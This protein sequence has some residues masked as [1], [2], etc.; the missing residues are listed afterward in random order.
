VAV[1]DLNGDGSPDIITSN[2]A[3]NT[4]SALLGNG[5]G[6]FQPQVTFSTDLAPVQTVI[7]DVNGD[8]RP[9]LITV[10][11]HDASVSVLI[12]NGD[13]TF[14]PL[15]NATGVRVVDTPFLADINGDGI[16]DSV[17]MDRSGNI[18]F[19][20]GL[21]GSNDSF[22]PPV[23]LNPGRPARDIAL[24]NTV[25]GLAIAAADAQLDPTLSSNTFAI[26]ISLYTI[27]R[28]GTVNRTV[29]FTTNSLPT[30]IA[31]ADLLGNGLDSIV[32]ADAL[33][34]TVTVALQTAPGVFAAP[35]TVPVGSAPADITFADVNG[36]G[37]PDIVVSDQASGEV[38][39]LLN[40]ANHAFTK[41]LTYRAGTLPSSASATSV[42]SAEQSVSVV[43]GNFLGTG[44]NDVV[45]VNAGAHSF[46]VLPNSGTGIEDPQ[47]S[48]TTSTS[49][50]FAIN[51][52]PGAVV[53]G[54]FNRDG[55]LDLAVLMQDTGQ[56]WIYTNMGNGIFR[57]TF[58]IPVGDEATGLSVVPGSAPGS[59]DLLVGNGFGD[60]LHLHGK[61]DGTFQITGSHVSLSAVP[62]LLGPGQAAVLVGNQQNSHVTI[63][64]ASSGSTQFSPVQS[65]G[66]TATQLAPGDVQWFQL[67]RSGSLPDP[68]VVSS[69]SNS[70]IVYHTLG[71]LGGQLT[72]APT[73]QTFFVGTTPA[74]VTVADLTG[75]GVPDLVLANQGSNDVSIIFGSYDAHGNWVGTLGPRL[76]SGGDGPI[77]TSVRNA[78]RDGI[79]DLVVTN[80]GSGTIT[81]LP[82]VG[83][84]FFDDQHPQT[85][86]N[87]GAALLQAPTFV[88][89]T[90]L[91]YT[92]TTKG[93]VVRF[94]LDAVRGGSNVAFA[95]HNVLAAQALAN[96]QVVV[97]L[98]GG[99]VDLLS[100][101]GTSLV[102]S[103]QLV[104]QGGLP[105]LPSALQVL[106]TSDGHVEVLV[107]NQGS[108]AIFAFSSAAKVTTTPTAT[109][110]GGG[111]QLS[112]SNTLT[113]TT[114]TTQ[115]T[116]ATTPSNTSGAGAAAASSATASAAA[117]VGGT[118][119]SD[120]SAGAAATV[121]LVG[122]QGSTYS[123]VAVLD[124][125][126][127]VDD[128][129]G[130]GS[131]RNPAVATS[132]S[133]GDTS[134]LMQ[135]VTGQDEALRQ[136]RTT[137]QTSIPENTQLHDPWQEDLFHR[138][139]GIRPLPRIE[140]KNQEEGEDAPY[141]T[142]TNE[143]GLENAR[144]ESDLGLLAVTGEE[145]FLL[146]FAAAARWCVALV[147][148]EVLGSRVHSIQS[149]LDE[150]GPPV[151]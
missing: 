30:R 92:V 41:T 145:P 43:A 129:T 29:A 37:L 23:I 105:A 100:P 143:I 8:G 52:Q 111:T 46:S 141:D 98:A 136:Y 53:A 38:T 106:Q 110:T 119:S 33:D 79:P 86:F 122:I 97:A 44:R 68:V 91:G 121:A 123:T 104:A 134:P 109:T 70:V 19:R 1:A 139:S 126:S 113:T 6:T 48:L 13:A 83:L 5:N 140:A 18:L 60:F 31:A 17:I 59:L 78:N 11:N 96:G 24:V 99:S 9:D 28:D 56:V 151:R 55:R 50:R 40:D 14:Q 12:N 26:A 65:L 15:T 34:N 63:Q 21:P 10:N 42:S 87:F 101:Q 131:A 120:T 20:A 137:V 125:G 76:K 146:Q 89:N 27:A 112:L 72:F 25:S 16:P 22:A 57:H 150:R 147:C 94:N 36:D 47:V 7:S 58:T 4:V 66:G 45:V 69:G 85:L 144:D 130:T 32:V 114:V 133:F 71:I 116:S 128:P 3:S 117:A 132:R 35:I 135:F 51:N 67:N 103:Q 39:V 95:G 80:G 102:V 115:T 108:D 81:K 54:D 84:G 2:Y 88:G 127:Q 107:S 148:A 124:F 82:G 73:P 142:D 62:N 49:K 75:N 74:S 138:Q 77:A 90:G 64:T 61:G 149:W 93:D 118:F